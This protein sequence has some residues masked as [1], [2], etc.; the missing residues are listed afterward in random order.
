MIKRILQLLFTLVALSLLIAG[1]QQVIEPKPQPINNLEPPKTS[2]TF[3][4]ANE[5]AHQSGEEQIRFY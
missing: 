4:F 5:R 2:L 3:S 1:C